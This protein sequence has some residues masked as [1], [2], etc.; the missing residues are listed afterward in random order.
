MTFYINLK[1]TLSLYTNSLTTGIVST[2]LDSMFNQ[3]V[4]ETMPS[5][6]NI[7]KNT[8]SEHF[9]NRYKKNLIN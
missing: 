5:Q 8:V 7:L 3:N 2:K 9:D 6:E 1:A 4:R